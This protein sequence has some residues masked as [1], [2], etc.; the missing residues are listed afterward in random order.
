M[1]NN[2][3]LILASGALVGS[4]ILIARAKN[5]KVEAQK[6]SPEPTA[7]ALVQKTAGEA[8]E[9]V[10]QVDDVIVDSVKKG[11]QTIV[12]GIRDWLGW[13]EGEASS[14]VKGVGNSAGSA[15]KKARKTT[16]NNAWDYWYARANQPVGTNT[17]L[18]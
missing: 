7:L 16:P 1:K 6:A 2:T 10:S 4:A 8:W 12:K 9:Y 17:V 11:G 13:G 14:A 3:K 5:K 18:R 15:V